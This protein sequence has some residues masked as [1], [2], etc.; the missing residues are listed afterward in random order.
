VHIAQLISVH[1]RSLLSNIDLFFAAKKPNRFCFIEHQ[2]RSRLFAEISRSGRRRWLQA[3]VDIAEVQKE[4]QAVQAGPKQ[5][6]IRRE[7][8]L[9]RARTSCGNDQRAHWNRATLVTP[10][11]RVSATNV[12]KGKDEHTTKHL[13]ISVTGPRYPLGQG[14]LVG[15]NPE[16]HESST[17]LVRSI[18]PTR[19]GKRRPA[20]G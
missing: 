2:M 18:K 1:G 16:T 12:A 13:T 14:S 9:S 3:T 19:E 10:T 17:C 5:R 11:V 15:R 8:R 7:N 4:S 6:E 20:A